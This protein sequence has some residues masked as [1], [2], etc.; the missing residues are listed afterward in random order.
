MR[1]VSSGLL[2]GRCHPSTPP[3]PPASHAVLRGMTDEADCGDSARSL[4]ART[5]PVQLTARRRRSRRPCDPCP[6]CAG[7][8][9]RLQVVA[10]ARRSSAIASRT[11]PGPMPSRAATLSAAVPA[12]SNVPSR[13]LAA[14]RSCASRNGTPSRT[15]ASAAS[16]ASTSG[17]GR[18]LAE[19]LAVDLEP[20]DEHRRA[21]AAPSRV[22]RA[23]REDGCLVLLQ[24][25]V[26]GERQAL[27]GRE[28]AREPADRRARLAA[29]EL[30]DV[31]VELL[32]HHRRAGGGVLGQPREAELA[33]RPQHDLLADPREVRVED[34]DRVEVVE[35]EVAVGDR[36]DRV[37]HLAGGRRQAERRAGE[38][39]GAERALPPRRRLRAQSARGRGRASRPRP[40]G[41]GRASPAGRAADACSRASACRP[42]PRRRR[43]RRARARRSPRAPPPHASST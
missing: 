37:P 36:V 9:E 26:V 14:T 30:G 22:S 24:V 1:C 18:R 25:A 2:H 13:T 15:S 16:V 4:N 10:E 6:C 27:D 8:L 3:R 19:A 40:A 43:G 41:D 11:P 32:R 7:R 31:G 20:G 28:Q 23:R 17:I 12:G 34:G 21:P 29:G 5:E 42:P 33:R 38:R 35:R 39:T